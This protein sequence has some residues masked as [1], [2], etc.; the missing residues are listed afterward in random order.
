MKTE[1]FRELNIDE[2]INNDGVLDLEKIGIPVI[3][4]G[5]YYRTT[6]KGNIRFSED[7]MREEFECKMRQLMNYEN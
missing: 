2:E 1:D 4:L 7:E 6:S 3:K 5:I